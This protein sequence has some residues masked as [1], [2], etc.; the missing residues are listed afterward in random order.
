MR[1]VL[2]VEPTEGMLELS[3]DNFIREVWNRAKP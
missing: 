2:G 3:D 1:Q